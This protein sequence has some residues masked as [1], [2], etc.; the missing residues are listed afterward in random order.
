MSCGEI[1]ALLDDWAD[2][3]LDEG[4]RR[5]LEAHAAAC[6]ECARWLRFEKRV[7]DLVARRARAPEPPAYLEGRIRAAIAARRAPRRR[8]AWAPLAVLLAVGLA[9]AGSA[10]WIRSRTADTLG[11]ALLADH[12][13]YAGVV[14]AREIAATEPERIES[15]LREVLAFDARLPSLDADPL[16]ARLCTVAGKRCGLVFYEREGLP[17]SLF[18]FDRQHAGSAFPG[19]ASSGGL[20]LL[21][22]GDE[23]RCYALVGAIPP[24]D[25]ERVPGKD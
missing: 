22:W 5:A 1:R 25:L 14:P 11:R 24:A 4:A 8:P 10:W 15:W 23:A 18:V 13:K 2:G 19:R 21:G 17:L 6:P 16:G 20:H 7:K 9:V 3:E 12:A